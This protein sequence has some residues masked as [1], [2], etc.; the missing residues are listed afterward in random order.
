[1][2]CV[3]CTKKLLDRMRVAPEPDP[4][5][6]STILGDWYANILHV[7]KQQFIVCVSEKT[8]LPVLLPALDAKLLPRRLPEALFDVLK[9]LG[10]PWSAIDREMRDMQEA[11]VG[12]TA[13]RSVLGILN[14]FAFAAPYRLVEGASLVGVALWLAETPCKPIKMNS[15]DRETK[16]AFAEVLH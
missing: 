14:E 6:P 12:R 3:R 5:A 10:I 9:T 11:T 4:P 15:P 1:V 13:N 16:A 7:G 8:L 2:F